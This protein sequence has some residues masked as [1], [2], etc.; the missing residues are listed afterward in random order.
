MAPGNQANGSQNFQDCYL[1]PDIFG[2]ETLSNYVDAVWMSKYMSSA[3]LFLT[4]NIWLCFIL[5]YKTTSV[6]DITDIDMFS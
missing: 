5:E 1:C 2:G 6:E 3:L 4:K